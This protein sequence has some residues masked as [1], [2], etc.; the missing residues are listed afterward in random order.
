MSFKKII[1]FIFCFIVGLLAHGWA[2]LAIYYCSFPSVIVLRVVLAVIYLS[3]VILFIT[4]NRRHVLAFVLSFLGFFVV[5]GW[6]SSIQ[7][8]ADGFYPAELTLP[9]AEINND[10]VTLHNVRNCAYRTKEDFDVHYETRVYDLKNLKTLDV[11]V[12]YWGMAA[13]AHTFLSFGFSDGQYLAV[14][15]EIRPEVGKAY[16]MLQGFFKQYN[17][18]YIWADERDLVRLRT[19]YKKEDVYL[20]RTTLPP[21]DVQKMFV[22]MLEGTN[23]IYRKP[24]FYNTFTHSCTNTLANHVVAAGIEKIPFWK[25]RVL[26]GNVDRRLYEDG[27]LDRSVPF[28]QLRRQANINERANQADQDPQFSKRIRTHLIKAVGKDEMFSS[29]ISFLTAEIPCN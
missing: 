1:F 26:T 28:L 3:A 21:G 8:R 11:L 19:N 16:D 29:Q 7:P 22:S 2:A 14:S 5:V 12:N 13:I 25:H 10:T 9:F 15:V 27:A 17:L 24:Q 20:Y 4:I 6:F 18:I 23:A